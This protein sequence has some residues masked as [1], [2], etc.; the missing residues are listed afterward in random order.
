MPTLEHGLFFEISAQAPRRSWNRELQAA[1]A[2]FCFPFVLLHHVILYTTAGSADIQPV[3]NTSKA[4]YTSLFTYHCSLCKEQQAVLLWLSSKC[5]Q[6]SSPWGNP[7]GHRRGRGAAA[8]GR[9]RW[10]GPARRCC[11]SGWAP[12]TR[13]HPS[14]GRPC[15][16]SQESWV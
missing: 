11:T 2:Y 12:R 10:C 15:R 5:C 6:T 4:N 1:T 16:K 14:P 13:P 8:R 9:C 7:P 3:L